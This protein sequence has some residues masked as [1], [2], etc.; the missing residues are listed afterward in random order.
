MDTE[1]V[2]QRRDELRREHE[3]VTRLTNPATCLLPLARYYRAQ[4]FN[5]MLTLLISSI[6]SSNEN[7]KK[8]LKKKFK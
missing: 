5:I 2:V 3:R 6:Q 8:K 1:N 7:L 4:I